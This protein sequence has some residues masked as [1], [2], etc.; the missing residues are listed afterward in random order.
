MKASGKE[1]L[2]PMMYIITHNCDDIH[3]IAV[4]KEHIAS[5][6]RPTNMNNAELPLYLNS[7][8]KMRQYVPTLNF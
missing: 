5:Y 2:P 7:L 8:W 3:E 6:E 4:D 1:R